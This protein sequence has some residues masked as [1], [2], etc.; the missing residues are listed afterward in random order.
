[1]K[2]NKR[3]AGVLVGG[4]SA[5]GALAALTFG[6]TSALFSSEVGPQEN[7]I[8]AGS[9]SLTENDD[10]SE[11]LT[12]AGLMPGDPSAISKFGLEYAGNDS[13]VGIDLLVTSVA[14]KACAVP[15]IANTADLTD[16]QLASCIE[17]GTQ[18][19]YNG[20]PGSGSF[21]MTVTPYNFN[22]PTFNT[23]IT[24]TALQAATTCSADG[25]GLITC[26]AEK[27]NIV[28]IPRGYSGAA[29]NLIWKDGDDTN[30][31]IRS[32]LPLSAPNA[33]QGSNVTMDVT[34]HAV[35]AAN[36][37]GT[38]AE[39]DMSTTVPSGTNSGHAAVLWPK[40]WS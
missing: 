22:G 16:A 38:F 14:Q 9:N 25:A 24:D 40:T 37:G 20:V 28:S 10:V 23:L 29:D 13:F 21:D 5:V 17:T 6:G 3:R 30:I 32:K 11:E 12:L 2:F 7:T 15:G 8:T 33:F 4:V 39:R 34:A 27:K 19:M 36:N 26:V 1:M 35:Q 31:E 18:P